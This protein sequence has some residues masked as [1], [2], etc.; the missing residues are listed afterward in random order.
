MMKLGSTPTLNLTAA[1]LRALC[2]LEIGR[3]TDEKSAVVEWIGG[4]LG[5]VSDILNVVNLQNNS[6]QCSH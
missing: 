5:G 2:S 6:K 3:L 4:S 1:L